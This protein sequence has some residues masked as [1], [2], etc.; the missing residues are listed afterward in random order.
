M[1]KLFDRIE[2]I[3]ADLDPTRTGKVFNVLGDVFP[4]N[5]LEKMI[6]DLYARNLT[7]DVVKD[8]IVKQVDTARLRRITESTLEGLAKRELNLS[9][10]VGKSEEAKERRLVPEVIEDFFTQAAPIAGLV[11]K[12]D[13]TRAHIYRIGR[14]PRTLLPYGED[15]EPRF[16][17]WARIQGSVSAK[18]FPNRPY[19]RMVTPGTA[20]ECFSCACRRQTQTT[21]RETRSSSICNAGPAF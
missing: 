20:F 21:C 16:G 9:A 3:E 14:L 15:L 7:E 17:K 10:I 8:R 13:K 6:R 18:T 2:Q 12:T 19:S 5:Q 11:P 4:A 1:E